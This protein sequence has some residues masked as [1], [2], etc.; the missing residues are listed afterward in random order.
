M[1]YG[2]RLADVGWSAVE[3]AMEIMRAPL[4]PASRRAAELGCQ[5]P[6]PA[7]FDAWFSRCVARDRDERFADAG[8]AWSALAPMLDALEGRRAGR[9]LVLA[10]TA[11]AVIVALAVALVLARR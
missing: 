1:V 10:V 5:R 11:I 9:R 8:Q 7:G 3:V 2:G 4:V 6:L